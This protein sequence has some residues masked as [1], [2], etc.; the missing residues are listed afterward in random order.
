MSKSRQAERRKKNK[1]K[2]RKGCEQEN[3]K[4]A[5]KGYFKFFLGF[6]D[7]TEILEHVVFTEEWETKRSR[8][9]GRGKKN[10]KGRKFKVLL[11]LY[12]TAGQLGHEVVT[13]LD[14]ASLELLVESI[15]QEASELAKNSDHD[16]DL[17]RSY[18]VVR[19]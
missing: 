14:R 16:I 6:E 17:R 10:F 7:Y 2:A 4:P 13:M 12:N 11:Y 15:K 9:L 5:F 1:M 8:I 3:F 19:V 18:A